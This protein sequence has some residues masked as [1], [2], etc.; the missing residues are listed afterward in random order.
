VATNAHVVDGA[1]PDEIK[2]QF[3]DEGNPP[4]R[5]TRLLFFDRKKDLCLLEGEMNLKSLPVRSDYVLRPGDSVTLMG[6]PSV[7][8]GILMRNAICQGTLR[9]LVRIEGRDLYHIDANVNPGWSGGPVLDADGAVIA[10]VAMKAGDDAAEEIRKAMRKLDDQF[11]AA[12]AA[13]A[14]TAGGIAYGIPGSILAQLLEKDLAQ[15]KD[16]LGAVNEKFAAQTLLQRM[17]FLAGLAMLRIQANVPLQVRLEAKAFTRGNFGVQSARIKNAKIELVPIMSE[18]VAALVLQILE[19]EKIK[20]IE[21]HILKDMDAR[22]AAVGESPNISDDVKRNMKNLAGKIKKA[23]AYAQQP[24]IT[25]AAF[26][27]KLNEF[28]REFKQIGERLEKD[29]D[30]GLP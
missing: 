9:S 20:T 8:G 10:V 1:F 24:A 4:R 25:Y 16:R 30:D 2:V 15:D 22:L 11:R 23:D 21:R 28:S 12:D 14:S 7:E 26:S 29:L 13:D 27:V 18:K 19:G 17:S 6:N 3:G 5:I